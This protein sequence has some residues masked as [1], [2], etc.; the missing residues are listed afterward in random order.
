MMPVEPVI[1]RRSQEYLSVEPSNSLQ[2]LPGQTQPKLV[3]VLPSKMLVTSHPLS[4]KS[5][6]GFSVGLVVGEVDG[7][8]VGE[9]VGPL[10][11]DEVGDVEGD[12]VGLTEGS[13]GSTIPGISIAAQLR[14]L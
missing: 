4:G 10:V 14:P 5:A 2:G 1:L 13:G 11:G 8:L 3:A 12:K 7:D 9:T 6:V